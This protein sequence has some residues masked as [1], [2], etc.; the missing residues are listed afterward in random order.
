MDATIKA[1][2]EIEAKVEQLLKD[3]SELKQLDQQVESDLTK[4]GSYLD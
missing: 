4:L 2:E 1:K 3:K